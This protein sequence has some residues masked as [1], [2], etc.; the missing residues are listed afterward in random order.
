MRAA[1]DRAPCRAGSDKG[2]NSRLAHR[3]ARLKFDRPKL[4][5]AVASVKTTT[6]LEPTT[7]SARA[8]TRAGRAPAGERSFGGPRTGRRTQRTRCRR[9][10]SSPRPRASGRDRARPRSRARS[11]AAS[12][13]RA[14]ASLADLDGQLPKQASQPLLAGRLRVDEARR[15]GI[16]L[17]AVP[18]AFTRPSSATSRDIVAWVVRKPRSRSADASSCCV[19]IGR[20]HDDVADRPM[21]ELL[22]HLHRPRVARRS[23]RS[24]RRSAEPDDEDDGRE[25]DAVR[26]EH[27][28][29][30]GP[31]EPEQVEIAIT[32][33]RN[34]LDQARRRAARPR[35]RRLRPGRPGAPRTPAAAAVT[36]VAMR[37]LKRAASSR[38]GRRTARP[39]SRCPTG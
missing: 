29:R 18:G 15:Q 10:R 21:A 24:S 23:A 25:E 27:V 6:Q 36:G 3:V 35:R 2:K 17:G 1:P 34:E 5:R 20:G 9:R 4:A 26:D 28:G 19:R 39:R 31:Q 32:P 13:R 38:R 8:S 7:A 12:G 37:K 16:G 30:A 22:H 14:A 33:K 11:P